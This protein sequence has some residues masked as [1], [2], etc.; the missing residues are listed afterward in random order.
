MSGL[1][2]DKLFIAGAKCVASE[3]G[4][5]E[6]DANAFADRLCKEAVPKYKLVDDDEDDDDDDKSTWIGRNGWWAIPTG[7]G[8]G[9]FLLGADAGRNGRPDRGYLSNAGNLLWERIQALFGVPNS[10]SWRSMTQADPNKVISR[11][12]HDSSQKGG[13]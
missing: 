13:S 9:A 2:L 1:D 4:M 10:A 12:Q 11:M 6:K 5:C 7:V 3:H 8:L